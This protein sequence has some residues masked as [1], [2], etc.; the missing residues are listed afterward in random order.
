M[1]SHVKGSNCVKWSQDTTLKTNHKNQI[2]IS[3]HF[4]FFPVCQPSKHAGSGPDPFR[5]QPVMAITASRNRPGS[6][7]PDPHRMLFSGTGSGPD[8]NQIR[9]CASGLLPIS[10]RYAGSVWPERSQIRPASSDTDPDHIWHFYSWSD[11]HRPIRIGSFFLHL[12]CFRY[13]CVMPDPLG[14]NEVRSDPLQAKRIRTTPL[15]ALEYRILSMN[16]KEMPNDCIKDTSKITQ[17]TNTWT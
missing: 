12:A 6:D 8:P 4:V 16:N 5:M 10:M 14:L 13:W 1:K 7:L 17:Y 11:G 2:K 15:F 9:F 3:A